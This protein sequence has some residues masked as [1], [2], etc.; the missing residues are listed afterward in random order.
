M[1]RPEGVRSIRRE[2]RPTR[3]RIKAIGEELDRWDS[4]DSALVSAQRLH[5]GRERCW[6]PS[7][8]EQAERA[9]AQRLITGST[10]RPD[11]SRP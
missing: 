6:L 8:D 2:L 5:L 9:F 11:R 7:L 1:P 3:W 4:Y 10:C